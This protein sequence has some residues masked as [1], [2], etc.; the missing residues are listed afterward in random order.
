M[1]DLRSADP[2]LPL[3]E[4]RC[5]SRHPVVMVTAL[6]PG[7]PLTIDWVAGA[8]LK[9]IGQLGAQ[10]ASFL[11]ALHRPATLR[12][13]HESA[14]SLETPRPQATTEAIRARLGAW[15]RPDQHSI[16]AA[17][18]EWADEVLRRPAGQTVF[19]HGDLHGHN[20]IWDLEHVRLR[21]VVDFES[22]GPGEAEFD[23]RY[24]PAQGPTVDLL[25]ET[26]S[27]YDRLS[28]RALSLER[29]MAWHLRTVLG[30]ALWRSEA[31]VSLPDGGTPSQWVDALAQRFAALDLGPTPIHP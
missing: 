1:T 30:D 16:V 17:W 2:A 12:R 28:G 13:V 24:L 19:L 31:S 9:R 29:V 11:V 10:L 18:C 3:P 23:L 8:G 5:V 21:A 26:M 14:G 22:A 25:T 20:Q 6:V 27:H 15:L 4:V 7:D